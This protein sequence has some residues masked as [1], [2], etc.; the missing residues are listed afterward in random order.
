VIPVLILNITVKL[1]HVQVD[2]SHQ[3]EKYINN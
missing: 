1:T 3:E 2:V